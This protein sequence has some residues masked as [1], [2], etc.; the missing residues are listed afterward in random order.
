MEQTLL[1]LTYDDGHGPAVTEIPIRGVE[2]RYKAVEGLA[3][4]GSPLV[5][6]RLGILQEMLDEDRQREIF[7][8]SS[9]AGKSKSDEALVFSTV[10]GALR[11]LSELHAKNPN[12]DLSSFSDAI[13]KLSHSTNPELR[14]EAERTQIALDRK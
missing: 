9:N 2:I 13:E 6:K 14:S 5:E 8:L 10:R 3:R 7:R 11:G 4:R 12:V 1:E